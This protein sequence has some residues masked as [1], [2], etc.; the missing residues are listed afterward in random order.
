MH[1][2]EERDRCEDVVARRDH[3]SEGESPFET[4]RQIDQCD[5][6]RQQDRDDRAALELCSD[7][8]TNSFRTLYGPVA[9]PEVLL[10]DVSNFYGNVPRAAG[11]RRNIGL[12]LRTDGELA[13]RSELLDLG[14]SDSRLVER[15]TDFS[16]V[17]W[18]GELQLHQ[19]AA[20][21][22]NTV[23][24]CLDGERS[25]SKQDEGDGDRRHHLPPTDE[26][27]VRV[28]KNAKH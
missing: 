15:R 12:T 16:N 4:D 7:T 9:V 25:E 2:F 8:R 10:Q 20:S 1:Q 23:I 17:R 18:L 22:L 3:G 27:V 14:A 19:S 28:V 13:V 11:L 6:K 5:Q 21:E 26:I 24:G